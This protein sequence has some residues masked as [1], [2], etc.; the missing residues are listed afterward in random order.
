LVNREQHLLFPGGFAQCLSTII[1]GN[2]PPNV[3]YWQI[4][5]Q[6]DFAHPAA[7]DRFKIGRQCAMLI[8]KSMRL[9][10]IV[11][12]FYST[13]SARRLLQQYRHFCDITR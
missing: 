7:Q 1:G 6:N 9:D 12:N 2:K 5:L 8:Q 4:V 10:S 3:A 11:S 13:A